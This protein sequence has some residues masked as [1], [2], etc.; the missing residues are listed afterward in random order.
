MR[1]PDYHRPSS[2]DAE[3]HAYASDI[4]PFSG[5]EHK[6]WDPTLLILLTIVTVPIGAF[7]TVW[8]W[9][10]FEREDYFAKNI[11]LYVGLIVLIIIGLCISP[12]MTSWPTGARVFLIYYAVISFVLLTQTYT[13]LFV[14]RSIYRQ[15]RFDTSLIFTAPY[16]WR[17]TL[18]KVGA[19]FAVFYGLAL[20]GTFSQQPLAQ[21]VPAQNFADGRQT[22][23]AAERTS[24]AI[25]RPTIRPT[26]RPTL[27]APPFAGADL[28]AAD[29]DGFRYQVWYDEDTYWV[30]NSADA[31]CDPALTCVL[32]LPS[33]NG[34]R[35]SI[36]VG[37]RPLDAGETIFSALGSYAA[38]LEAWQDVTIIS[39]STVFENRQFR[40]GAYSVIDGN[41][42]HIVIYA[43]L[44]RDARLNVVEMAWLF[45]G[46]RPSQ[47]LI[48]LAFEEMN[49]MLDQFSMQAIS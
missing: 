44:A 34:P 39:E 36:R 21:T 24:L 2:A 35:R 13:S 47:A 4:V 10:R 25:L 12:V 18:I 49:T 1:P 7:V 41:A 27:T 16:P 26:I 29:A 19:F 20:Y 43:F 32:V 9:R 8:N 14:Q 38:M 45:S 15:A 11:I 6:P 23:I 28:A 37:W 33:I 5:L 22:A 42:A 46:N 48:D 40:G 3:R 17:S 30:D 31:A